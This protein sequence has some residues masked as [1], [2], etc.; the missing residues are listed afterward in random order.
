MV[1][2]GN[3][4]AYWQENLSIIFKL[5]AIWFIFSFIFGIFFADYLN[6]FEISGVKFG[7]FL[8]NQG[9]IYL[10]I[11][12]IFIYIKK[13]SKLDEKYSKSE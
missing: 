1:D 2:Q 9:L 7:Y 10:F 5:L 8:A 6:T 12:L 4:K 3:Y 13:M 11:L